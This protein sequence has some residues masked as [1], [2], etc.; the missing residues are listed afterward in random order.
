M[1]DNDPQTGL[2]ENTA[3]RDI[4]LGDSYDRVKRLWLDQ[5]VH[6]ASVR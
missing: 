6:G 2:L 3:M 1:T 5:L 4:F